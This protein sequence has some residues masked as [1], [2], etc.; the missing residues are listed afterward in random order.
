MPYATQALSLVPVDP[1]YNYIL[2]ALKHE[3]GASKDA[4]P[5]LQRSLQLQPWLASARYS[6][7][8]ALVELGEEDGIKDEDGMGDVVGTLV[9]ESEGVAEGTCVG[10]TH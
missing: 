9:G 3:L 1:D 10:A 8:L 4:V 5:F 7:G 6:L 2:G